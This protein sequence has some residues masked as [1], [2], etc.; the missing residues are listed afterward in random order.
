[1]KI[2]YIIGS[3]SEQ[4]LNRGLSKVLVEEAPEDVE[5][6]EIPIK[7]LP[8]YNRDFDANYPQIALDLKAEIEGADGIIFVTPEHN[9]TFSASLHNALEWASR[10][11]GQLSLAGKPVATIGVSPS[12]IGTAVAQRQLRS[13]LLFTGALVMGQPEAY[14]SGIQA[15]IT[16]DGG[17]NDGG[18]EVVSQWVNAAVKFIEAHK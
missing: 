1:M 4:S 5:F 2:G 13:S 14:I 18:R 15:E 17:I 12:G 11:Y 10:P 3:L 9:R 6:F 7:D 16:P 8:L